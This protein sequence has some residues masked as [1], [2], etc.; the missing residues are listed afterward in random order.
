MSEFDYQW[1]NL[2]SNFIEYSPQRVSELL[3]FTKIPK[4]WFKDKWCLDA[5]CG[6]GRYSYALKQLGA[7]VI[8][9]DESMEAVKKC[10]QV[11]DCY[12]VS[13]TDLSENE[14]DFVL[15]W[16]VLHHLE[17]P[18]E[19][20]DILSRQLKPGGILHIMVYSKNTQGIYTNHRKQFQQLNLE[21]RIALCKKL[22]GGGNIHGWWDALNPKFN[23][24][25]DVDE[26]LSWFSGFKNVR[27][28]TRENININGVK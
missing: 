12:N 24:A 18:K 5:G 17:N 2:P 7:K 3:N 6:N 22:S 9:I 21:G 8:A 28:I 14:Y 15:C 1:A 23:H 20:F 25:F 13:I 27:V 4:A 19:G 10:K 16:G 26:V 11:A